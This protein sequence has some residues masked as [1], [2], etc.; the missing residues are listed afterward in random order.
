MKLDLVHDIQLAYRK[1]IDSMSR[2]GTISRFGEQAG[3]IESRAGCLDTTILLAM[4]L[5]DTEVTFKIYSEREEEITRL[6]N[7]LT[8]S[9]EAEAAYADYI[10]VLSDADTGQMERAVRSAKTGDLVNPHLSATLIVEAELIANDMHLVLTGPGIKETAGLRVLTDG[11][12]IELRADKNSEYPMGIDMIFVDRKHQ[13]VC[14]PR[15]TQI[16]ERVNG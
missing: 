7:Q 10:F 12:W 8:Y 3:A 2:P 5:L 15:T 11:S 13:A 9:K 16:R 4:V 1:L 6:F 14:I